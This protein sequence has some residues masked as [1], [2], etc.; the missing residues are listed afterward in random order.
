MFKKINDIHPVLMKGM[1][2]VDLN[3]YGLGRFDTEKRKEM[4]RRELLSS[5]N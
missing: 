5:K 2:F 4:K 3:Q 1:K